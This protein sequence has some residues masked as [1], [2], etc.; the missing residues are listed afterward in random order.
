ML[1]GGVIF[2][3][4][5]QIS[6]QLKRVVERSGG[7]MVKVPDEMQPTAESL[8][9]LD[10]EILAQAADHRPVLWPPQRMPFAPIE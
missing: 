7:Q 3:C 8:K 4:Q 5:S 2:M 9:K 6:K 10:A 1:C